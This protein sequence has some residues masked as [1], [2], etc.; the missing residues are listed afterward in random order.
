MIEVIVIDN[1][2]YTLRRI[3]NPGYYE[4]IW[5][6]REI[7]QRT[8]MRYQYLRSLERRGVIAPIARSSAGRLIW[9]PIQAYEMLKKIKD[10]LSRRV[11]YYGH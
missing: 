10:Y 4:A 1:I 7:R 5:T 9:E 8:G 11:G 2:T 3:E 6:T